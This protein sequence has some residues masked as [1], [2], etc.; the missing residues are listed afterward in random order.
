MVNKNFLT[1]GLSVESVARGD[2]C[3]KLPLKYQQY[4][5]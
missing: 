4:L 2:N 5:H 1:E 3:Q